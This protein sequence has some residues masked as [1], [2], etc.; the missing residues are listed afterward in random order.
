MDNVGVTLLMALLYAFDTSLLQKHEDGEKIVQELPIIKDIGYAQDIYD[1]LKNDIKWEWDDKIKS[2]VIF[3]FGLAMTCL[4]QAPQNLQ[5][6]SLEIIE[7]DEQLVDD[8]IY[9]RVFDFIHYYL[10]ESEIIYK[11]V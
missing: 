6:N 8:A 2:I 4:R 1:T 10:L 7:K 3:A 11:Y 9:N 5:E